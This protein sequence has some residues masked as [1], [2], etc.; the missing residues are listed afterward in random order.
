MT[1]KQV[2]YV[3][4][5]SPDQLLFVFDHRSIL[6]LIEERQRGAG[7]EFIY[8]G[9]NQAVA[10]SGNTGVL[11]NMRRQNRGA[12]GSAMREERLI[13]EAAVRLRELIPEARLVVERRSPPPSAGAP[14]GFAARLQVHG[15]EAD[16]IG[17]A[18]GGESSAG[19]RARVA[20]LKRSLESASAGAVGIIVAPYLSRGRR[21]LIR[22]EGLA[23]VDL[24]GNAYLR[25]GPVFIH[26]HGDR[27]LHSRE[28]GVR[29]AFSGKGALVSE[30]LLEEPREWGV[31]EIAAAVG[32]DPG[33]VSRVAGYLEAEQYIFRREGRVQLSR[34]EELLSDWAGNYRPPRSSDRL[35]FSQ[36]LRAEDLLD[37]L[38][39]VAGAER[40]YALSNQA[41]ASLVAPYAMVDRVDA[42]V[43]DAA[44][45]A[46]FE[47]D[48]EL[49]P[50]DSG[51]NVVLHVLADPL[52]A[53]LRLRR[54]VR[55][56]WVVSD[57]RLYLD[58]VRYP[59]RGSEQADHL[60]DAVMRPRWSKQGERTDS[61]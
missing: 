28:P 45:L 48:L 36:A 10:T 34:P 18:Y 41:G 26:V 1:T 16:L 43:A 9:A 60:L 5:H 17:E 13:E 11:C 2:E 30:L 19:L 14:Q 59:R 15:W 49:R 31:R 40:A 37:R 55:G 32:L 21:D 6:N 39:A 12:T 54:M 29:R 50:V 51:A 38:D 20:L 33:H 53:V 42:Y 27:N 44:A 35:Y 23:Y 58:L 4:K 56:L 22:D 61:A 52:D 46:W 7:Y 25:S 3:A 24:S 47:R 8:L 57:V